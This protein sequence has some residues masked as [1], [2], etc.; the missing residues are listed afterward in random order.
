MNYKSE[1]RDKLIKCAKKVFLTNGFTKASLRKISSDAG[2]TTGAVY[3]FFKDKDGLLGAIVDEPLNKIL[4]VLQ[5]HFAEDEQEDFTSYVH[6][7]GDHDEL[8]E[9]LVSLMYDNYD[10]MII[11]LQKSAGSRYENIIDRIISLTEENYLEM[12]QKYAEAIKGKH[13]NTYMLHWFCHVHINAFVHLL[14]HEKNRDNA[15]KNIKSVMEFLICGW[16]NFILED[17]E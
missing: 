8:A 4:T 15:M 1:N 17:D 10:A 16:M 6:F 7:E 13:V 5:Q 3:F 9:T 12:A 2:L 14:E 11:L